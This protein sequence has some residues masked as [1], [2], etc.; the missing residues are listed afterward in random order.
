MTAAFPLAVHALVY[1]YHHGG[2]VISS[3]RLAENICTNPARV[4]KVMAL[5]HK[6]GLVESTKGQGSGYR[7]KPG[8]EA[9]DLSAILAALGEE[10]LE[11]GWRP[12]DLDKDCLI[13]SGMGAVM[14]EL[15]AD[16]NAACRARLAAMTIGQIDRKIFDSGKA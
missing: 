8:I 11:P 15:Y 12:G 10:T 14:D 5:L 4:R 16:L 3:T 9:L 7:A 13:S 2:E 1:L 6:A